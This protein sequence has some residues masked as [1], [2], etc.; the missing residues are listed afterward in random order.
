MEGKDGAWKALIED[1]ILKIQIL[2]FITD[3]KEE[4]FLWMDY[5][6]ASFN[7]RE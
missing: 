1:E 3:K 5:N 6:I 7:H 2:Y 4:R